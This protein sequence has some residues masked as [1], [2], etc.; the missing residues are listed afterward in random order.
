MVERG[1][2]RQTAA[3][4]AA[5]PRVLV[6]RPRPRVLFDP[7]L[8]HVVDPCVAGVDDADALAL[9][10]QPAGPALLQQLLDLDAQLACLDDTDVAPSDAVLVAALEALRRA[11][12][13]RAADQVPRQPGGSGTWSSEELRVH[14]AEE[15][16]ARL[17]VPVATAREHVGVATAL[18]DSRSA[19]LTA[20]EAGRIDDARART[21]VDALTPLPTEAAA[22]VQAQVLPS[23]GWIQRRA[24][25]TRLARAILRADPAGAARR[26]AEATEARSLRWWPEPDGQA[27]LQVR[28]PAAAVLALTS[29]VDARARTA[30]AADRATER[31]RARTQGRPVD[32]AAVAPLERYRFDV[33]LA[34]GHAIAEGALGPVTRTAASRP[35]VQVTVPAQALRGE[36]PGWADL[37]G[38]GPIT[39]DAAR[40]V[41]AD[42]QHTAG[43]RRASV[44]RTLVTDAATGVATAVLSPSG[45]H[46]DLTTR[47]DQ[48]DPSADLQRLVTARHPHCTFPGCTT[49]AHRCELD[50]ALP[51]PT[52]ATTAT[53]LHPLCRRHHLLEHAPA[54]PGRRGW[55]LHPRRPGPAATPALRALTPAAESPGPRRPA[56]PTTRRPIR[57]PSGTGRSPARAGHRYWPVPFTVSIARP[58]S[59]PDL[60]W[61]MVRM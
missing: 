38:H 8:A 55:T 24:L 36:A 40:T 28:G 23:A 60:P 29:A 7:D 10:A 3:P 26:A 20:L 44:A 6:R 13:E 49:P 41:L 56:T 4:A 59:V 48:H 46:V 25:T 57:A 30:R 21:L 11:E 32:P 27:C 43:P 37:A 58:G 51:W 52:G 1:L 22:A 54:P 35:V 39:L 5:S 18:A 16:A 61:M 15:V 31:D 17:H 9:A 53:N 12:A 50:H 33:L 14:T 34:A 19:T 45:R 47:E 42:A 2:L